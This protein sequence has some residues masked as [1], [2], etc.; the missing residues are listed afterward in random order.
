MK[1]K[2][3]LLFV[4]AAIS[5]V[6]CVSEKDRYVGELVAFT[7]EVEVMYEN[8]TSEELSLAMQQYQAFREEATYYRHE[9][10]PEDLQTIA[11]CN[12]RLNAILARGYI[13]EGARALGGFIEE[14][15][16][17]LEDL[18]LGLIE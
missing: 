9:F 18:G 16:H 12:R 10:T 4:A 15:A 5:L 11:D 2:F 13:E 1:S 14:A 8:Y 6:A 7:D 17:L 3:I